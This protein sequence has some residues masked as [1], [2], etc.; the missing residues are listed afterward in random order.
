M[1]TNGLIVVQGFLKFFSRNRIIVHLRGTLT[2]ATFFFAKVCRNVAT[3]PQVFRSHYSSSVGRRCSFSHPSIPKTRRRLAG[4]PVG[5]GTKRCRVREQWLMMSVA[6]LQTGR[7]DA[8]GPIFQLRLWRQQT[9]LSD[10]SSHTHTH[11]HAHHATLRVCLVQLHSSPFL[12]NTTII[13]FPPFFS[14]FLFSHAPF[15]QHSGNWG[16]QDAKC[17][18][19]F[20]SSDWMK[21]SFSWM[22]G[23]FHSRSLME[24]FHAEKLFAIMT[25]QNWKKAPIA[26]LHWRVWK[27]R[28]FWDVRVVQCKNKYNHCQQSW[29]P[30]QVTVCCLDRDSKTWFGWSDLVHFSPVQ[31]DGSD[32]WT[33]QDEPSPVWCSPSS[34]V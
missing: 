18:P 25:L 8:E 9:G 31:S 4:E 10:G 14:L 5:G 1:N 12:C 22:W 16:S 20:T 17:A 6:E 2:L 13:L 15:W 32:R 7:T 33:N 27:P 11:T 26:F 24:V 30:W 28:S 29:Q 21:W 3:G 19:H 23:W 34:P